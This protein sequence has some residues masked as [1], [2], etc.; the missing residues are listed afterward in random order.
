MV[1]F[2]SSEIKIY[3]LNSRD[4]MTEE[5]VSENEDKSIEIIQSGSRKDWKNNKQSFIDLW[6]SGLTFVLLESQ[7]EKENGTK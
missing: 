5:R 3:W 4:A 1:K 7:K 6:G 2:G